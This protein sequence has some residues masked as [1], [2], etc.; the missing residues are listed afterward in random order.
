MLLLYELDN[1]NWKSYCGLCCQTYNEL[2]ATQ[3]K[4]ILC[5]QL[6]CSKPPGFK[7]VLR[8]GRWRRNSNYYVMNDL[9]KIWDKDTTI[10]HVFSDLHSLENHS[11]C[12]LENLLWH[13]KQNLD[14][15]PWIKYYTWTYL[16]HLTDLS[17][18]RSYFSVEMTR[19]VARLFALGRI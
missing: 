11:L 10:Q 15:G 6:I 17:A 4:A 13:L 8:N 16:L 3:R 14:P 1:Y 19:Q 9:R 2:T 18:S 7:K 12:P 5:E